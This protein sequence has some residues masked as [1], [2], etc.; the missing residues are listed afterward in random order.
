MTFG[1]VAMICV[2]G[3]SVSDCGP[4]PGFSRD[5]A[6]I[7]NTPNEIACAI[8]SQ[9]DLAK[10]SRFRDL[11]DGEFIKVHVCEEMMR[12]LILAFLLASTQA[13]ASE[14]CQPL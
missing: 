3:M 1:V 9:Q 6:V 5:V 12:E 7:G 10:S 11:A 8:E 14:L 2:V 4:Q 13:T